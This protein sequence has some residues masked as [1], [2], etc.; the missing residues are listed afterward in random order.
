MYPAVFMAGYKILV[1]RKEGLLWGIRIIW[2]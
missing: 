2:Q 1:Y